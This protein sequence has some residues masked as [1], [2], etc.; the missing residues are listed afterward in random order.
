MKNLG[1]NWFFPLSVGAFFCLQITI[2]KFTHVFSILLAVL[3]AVAV[4]GKTPSLLQ[5]LR[6]QKPWFLVFCLLTSIGTSLG[7]VDVFTLRIHTLFLNSDAENA[8]LISTLEGLASRFSLSIDGFIRLLDGAAL[9]A[10]LLS[11]FCVSVWT[12]FLLRRLWQRFQPLHWLE[13]TPRWELAVYGAMFL[14]AAVLSTVVFLKSQA[15]YGTD[16]YADIIYTTD[17]PAAV[18]RLWFLT[19]SWVDI[20]HPLFPFFTAPFIGFA[21]LLSKL[22]SPQLMWSAIL[23]NYTQILLLLFTNFLLARILHLTPGKRLCFTVPLFCTYACLF[24]CIALET[25]IFSCFWFVLF[26][27]L[28]F[29]QK[30]QDQVILWGLGGTLVTSLVLTPL[31]SQHCPV[32][33]FKAWFLD[34]WRAGL[35]FL[36]ALVAFG[37]ADFLLDLWE[38]IS[39][40]LNFTGGSVAFPDRVLQYLVFLPNCFLPPASRVLLAENGYMCWWLTVPTE[41]S[42]LGIG[43]LLAVLCSFLVNRKNEM[44]RLC[45]FWVCYSFVI[46][47]LIGWG[48]KENGLNLYALSFTWAIYTLLFQLVEKMTDRFNNRFALPLVCGAAAIGLSVVNFP[49]LYEMI[50]FAIQTY[51]S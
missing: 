37:N 22:F 34:M 1:R 46:L 40:T 8:G 6:G 39:W 10:G 4:A 2:F 45:F 48:T 31:M 18:K 20:K 11:L 7:C 3:A 43:I 41:V 16:Y 21:Y 23:M 9:L 44:N 29:E 49:A 5:Y 24:A 30:Q 13:D 42:K 12:V 36:F 26:L 33:S 17:S 32:R 14:G 28:I 15:F 47:C 51:P 19:D 27:Y 25:Y 38:Q 50:Q 35:G